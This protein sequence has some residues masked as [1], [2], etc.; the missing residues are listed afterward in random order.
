[1][2]FNLADVHDTILE[3]VHKANNQYLTVSGGSSVRDYGI[4]SLISAQIALELWKKANGCSGEIPLNRPSDKEYRVTLETSFRE[5]ADYAESERR[6]KRNSRFSEN[7]KADVVFWSRGD[8][9]IGVVEVKRQFGFSNLA[10]D[11][12]RISYLL[13][14]HGTKHGG[15]VRWAALAGMRELRS[16]ARKAPSEIAREVEQKCADSAPN[17]NFSARYTEELLRDPIEYGQGVW[18]GTASFAVLARLK[19][20]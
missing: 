15:S 10:E 16:N 12:K 8:K 18:T 13:R 7:Q 9:P 20:E 2:R 4:E 6:G 3:A 17:L 19:R 1:M 14:R 5:I 11:L